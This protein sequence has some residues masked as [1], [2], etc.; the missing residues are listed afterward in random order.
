[1][2]KENNTRKNI[3]YYLNHDEHGKRKAKYD[4]YALNSHMFLEDFS[5]V[6]PY[7]LR[8]AELKFELKDTPQNQI[9]TICQG[10]K[11]QNS[12]YHHDIGD[13]FRDFINEVAS[14]VTFFG[15]AYYE[16]VYFFENDSNKPSSFALERI[17][18]ED[19]NVKN[20]NAIVHIP[21]RVAKENSI[22]ERYK[23]SLDNLS[24]YKYPQPL[25]GRKALN[26]ILMEL[27]ELSGMDLTLESLKNN[28]FG[29]NQQAYF[30]KSDLLLAKATGNV[31]WDAR[32]PFDKRI[33]EYYKW[34]RLIEY[35]QSQRIFLNTI[36]GEINRVLSIV[37]KK[38]PVSGL[39]EIEGIPTIEEYDQLK[40][41]LKDGE[42]NFMDLVDRIL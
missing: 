13:T 42:I 31:K 25:G 18:Y 39:L 20:K 16:I 33:T 17:V 12:Y 5:R 8:K 6:V 29:F 24:V 40:N 10:F 7:K 21:K 26:K 38:I 41:S 3:R 35:K 1:M 32:G 9:S 36:I 28:D 27:S 37:C 2:N 23:I 22:K 15:E 30:Y 4:Y 14:E 19:I 34:W 11:S